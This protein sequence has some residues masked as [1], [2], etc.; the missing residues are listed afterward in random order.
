MRTN[1]DTA[2]RGGGYTGFQVTGMIEWGQKSGPKRKTLGLPTKPKKIPGP[3][4]NPQENPMPNFR[5]LKNFQNTKTLY[6]MRRNTR[7]GYCGHRD[8]DNSLF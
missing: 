3:K 4:I 6:F 1:Y 8:P 5:V 2:P 7:P